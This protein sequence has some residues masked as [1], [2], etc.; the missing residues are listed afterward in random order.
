MVS[1]IEAALVLVALAIFSWVSYKRKWLDNEGILI[2]N[3]V[4]LS[5]LLLG[6]TASL[7][8]LFVFFAV[9]EAATYLIKKKKAHGQ[10]T[11][12]NILGNALASIV[13]LLL[14]SPIGFF[15]AISAALADTLSS[16][17]GVLSK[18]KPWMIT[19]LKQVETGEDG[20]V[21]WLGLAAAFFGA[22]LMAGIAF[23]LD[24]GWQ[25]SVI[26]L[27]AGFLGSIIDSFFGAT[28][29]K[30]KWVDNNEVNFLGSSAGAL[31]AAGLTL[32]L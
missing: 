19:T 22:L 18:Q 11:T 7:V 8:V 4:G 32:L 2:A 10:R 1:V 25:Q 17:V 29:Q 12:A 13:A 5:T 23:A 26:V 6:G 27:I 15:G 31:I 24:F 14:G 9:G 16:E 20:G 28:I 30:R 3:I 21:S